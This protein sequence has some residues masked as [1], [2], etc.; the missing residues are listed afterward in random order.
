MALQTPLEGVQMGPGAPSPTPGFHDFSLP[1]CLRCSLL[2]HVFG[3]LRGP[4][5]LGCSSWP[6]QYVSQQ[7]QGAAGQQVPPPGG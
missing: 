7:G 1:L 6:E 3:A 4:T 2:A 5:A